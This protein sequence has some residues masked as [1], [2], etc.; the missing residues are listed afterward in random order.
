MSSTGMMTKRIALELGRSNS[1][2]KTRRRDLGLFGKRSTLR[3]IE[4]KTYLDDD[5]FKKV[6]RDAMVRGKST[7]S[8]I[9]YLIMR[10]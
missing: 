8:Y 1:A 9:K 6:T 10:A 4:V 2:V 3:A 7:S 5:A